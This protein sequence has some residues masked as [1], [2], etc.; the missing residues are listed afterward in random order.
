M[1]YLAMLYIEEPKDAQTVS[2][3]PEQLEQYARFAH[4]AR[5]AGVFIS[6]ETLKPSETATVVRA[7]ESGAQVTDGPYVEPPSAL[8]AV[9]LLECENLDQAIEWAARIPAVGRGAV[10]VRPVAQIVGRD[11]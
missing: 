2:E 9:Y 4:D 6:S 3:N 10:E 1:R 7:V 5:Q 8:S 11:E